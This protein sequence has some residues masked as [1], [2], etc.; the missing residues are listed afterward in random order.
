MS[1]EL[2]VFS[3]LQAAGKTSFYRERFIGTHVLVSKDLWP[4]ARNKEKR[5][6]CL[7]DEHLRYG[8]SVVVDNTNPTPEDREPLVALARMA[9][10]RVHSYTFIVTVDEALR[11]N[12]LREGRARIKDVGIF[13]VAKRFIAVAAAEGFDARF[14]VRLTEG[15][16]VVEMC[17]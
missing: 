12:A 5:Q 16:F 2:V 7:V 11:R 1:A 3:G 8:R 4:N 6:R 14:E 10:A 13:S 15:G 9:G 17:G